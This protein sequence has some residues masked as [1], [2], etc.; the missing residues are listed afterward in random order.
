MT[1]KKYNLE[2]AFHAA[3]NLTAPRDQSEFLAA[4]GDESRE[5]QA[6]VEQLLLAHEQA[7]RFL[8]RSPELVGLE[9]GPDPDEPPGLAATLAPGQ[10]AKP[11]FE[12]KRHE[13]TLPRRFGNYELLEKIAHG[14]MGVVYKARQTSLNRMVAIK[15]ILAGQFAS[16]DEVKRFQIEAKAAARLD[17]PGIVPVFE[18]G[19][20]QGQ[21]Y[22]SMGL[23]EGESLAARIRQGGVPP[24]LAARYV[25]K[26]AAAVEV[27][28]RQG[29]IH[30]DL[31]PGNILLDQNDEPRVTDF[32]MA[33]HGEANS[34]LTATG[35]IIGTPGYMPPEQASGDLERIKATADVYSL[36][37]I[38]YALLTG[39]P[40]FEGSTQ[41]ETLMQ[42]LHQDPVAPRQI[43]PTIPK[44]LQAVCLKCLEKNPADRY[45]SAAAMADDLQHFLAGE[46]ISAKNDLVRRL[47]KWT[48]REPVLASQLAAIAVIMLMVLVN[49]RVFGRGKPASLQVLWLNEGILLGWA[50]A[51]FLLQKIHNRLRRRNLIPFIWA[52][53]NPAFLTLALAANEP[54]RA[55]LYS[56]FVLLLI[57]MCFFRRIDLVMIT[58][59]ASLA[60]YAVLLALL[61]EPHPPGPP[62]S[63]LVTFAVTLGIAGALVSALALRMGRLDRKDTV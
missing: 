41:V 28:H 5:L 7:G 56:V 38:L 10:S 4:I 44:D 24:R 59:I 3:L 23:V 27:A 18:V 29:I 37:G 2:E 62:P 40:P 33:R 16:P 25:A 55:P 8:E 39:R 21:H 15:M 58:T 46:P 12:Q 14:G 36:G 50:G 22:F 13:E 42:V 48:V 43:V 31:K 57:S 26:I 9:L 34:E 35:T 49:F 20:C 61:H 53:S 47:R 1:G 30:R 63:Y 32:G 60:G 51:A 52:A 11:G 17:H 54:P 19:S 45:R 6:Q